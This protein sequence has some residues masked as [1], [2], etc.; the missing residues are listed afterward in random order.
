MSKIRE[1]SERL[2]AWK[3]EDGQHRAVILIAV[4]ET[5]APFCDAFVVIDGHKKHL[6]DA[7]KIAL[8]R[9][10]HT[11]AHITLAALEELKNG[12][13]PTDLNLN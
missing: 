5:Q 2:K 9:N 12:S 8:P 3:D 10:G 7:I 11:L 6:T 1:I 4:D 13:V